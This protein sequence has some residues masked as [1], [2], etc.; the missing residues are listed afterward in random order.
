MKRQVAS[1]LIAF[2]FF[3]MAFV[4]VDYL[5]FSLQGLTLIFAG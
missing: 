2:V 4:L 3:A 1:F 5:S